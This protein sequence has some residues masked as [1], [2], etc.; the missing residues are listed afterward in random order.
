MAN[1]IVSSGIT[2][3][4]VDLN[5]RDSMTVY[6][7]GLANYTNVN[8]AGVLTLSFGMADLT[9]INNGGRV[10]VLHDGALIRNT[11]I[12]S[13]GVM[14]VNE[15]ASA[16]NTVVLSGG[17]IRVSAGSSL[18]TSAAAGALVNGFDLEVASV[19]AGD[20]HFTS[21]VV[22]RYGA[23][24]CTRQ[25]ASHT[26]VGVGR[27]IYV[28]NSGYA[29]DTSLGSNAL[30][31]VM[32]GGLAENI[33][34]ESRSRIEISGGLASSAVVVGGASMS[35][36]NRGS[37]VDAT[38][39]SGGSMFISGYCVASN[40]LVSSGGKLN[41]FTIQSDTMHSSGVH[42]S[43]ATA[44]CG[45]YGEYAYIFYGQ[46]AEECVVSSGVSLTVHSS[47]GIIATTVSSGATAN[48]FT[49]RHDNYLSDGFHISGGSVSRYRTGVLYWNQ[50][51][52]DMIITSGGS[53][54]VS[55]GA[56]IRDTTIA[57]GGSM[58]I[59]S[60]AEVT[61][62]LTLDFTGVSGYTRPIIN[63]LDLLSSQADIRVTGLVPGYSYTVATSGSLDDIKCVSGL[64]ADQV[65]SGG[66]YTN[67]F[68]GATYYFDG[69]KVTTSSF[70][71][72]E[73]D[74]AMPLVSRGWEVN[75]VDLAARW[76]GNTQYVS[77][78]H[79]TH[80]MTQ[81][82][83]W[84]EI[85][86]TN[87]N[88]ALYGTSGGFAGTINW[89]IKS[90]TIRNLA[91]G[92][93]AGGSAGA[94]NLTVGAADFTGVVYAGG[95][96]SV[97]GRTATLIAGG[98]FTKDFYA[99]ALWNKLAAPTHVA[100]VVLTVDS[101]T[102]NGSVYGAS[103]VKTAAVSG[104]VHTA[105]DATLTLNGGVATGDEFC[106]F[107]GG[108]ATG[109]ATGVKVYTVDS[110]SVGV[111][112]GSWG[113][114][115]AAGRGLFGGV[116]ASGVTAEVLGD[117]NLS[118][119]DGT[120]F[121]VFGGGW[122]QKHGR[123]IVTGNVNI[124][125]TGGSVAN[126]F[127]GGSHS[128]SS[129][130]TNSTTS[131]AGDVNITISGGEITGAICGRGHLPGDEV[132]GDVTITFTGSGTYGCDVF[133]YGGALPAG[134]GE[135]RLVCRGFTGTLAGGIG[136]FDSIEFGG[137]TAAAFGTGPVANTAWC[138]DLAERDRKLADSAL[139]ECLGSAAAGK[140]TLKLADA[141]QA[142]ATGWTL[143]DGLACA[144]AEFDVEVDGILIDTLALGEQIA[145]GDFAG[146]GFSSTGGVLRFSR[147]A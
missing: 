9:T 44:Y 132:L 64:Y 17:S 96:G 138:F 140:V 116:F 93:D 10:H 120:L 28:Y 91:A 47:G 4:G 81:G 82:D 88:S 79:L 109:T 14:R 66:S 5:Y 127:G 74:I 35:V 118:V 146:W 55:S 69:Q 141:G 11:L 54:V 45:Q 56:G 21:C 83:G 112:G 144:D 129:V 106:C 87:V 59:V 73:A 103:A 8:S 24:I 128:T 3:T 84:L 131:V 62:H 7:G 53:V 68:A 67:V 65:A 107:G 18:L 115:A 2:S 102:F 121:N 80:T 39:Y 122:A 95:F 92:A 85:D 26:T 25:T 123:S 78:V 19:F 86:G 38:V 71:L 33:C 57:A 133:G 32:V 143:A 94:V 30:L 42:I 101:G 46:T 110:V 49:L 77:S 63:N 50:T 16:L 48:G 119:M 31:T 52:E 22:G 125:V 1:Y 15:G 61:G 36:V 12:N 135:A 137:D 40:T 117:V 114:R 136:G 6:R 89:N 13:G 124:S 126:I 58:R 51:A 97:G 43:G 134:G 111:N 23:E 41:G 70:E 142:T 105:G 76:T 37:T 90:G 34:T 130:S 104:V 145:A 113:T 147:L 139:L 100:D 98:S 20:F 72:N 29:F 75:G 99:G 108:Y 27:T 60:G